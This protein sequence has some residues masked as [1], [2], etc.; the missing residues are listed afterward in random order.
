MDR[1][2]QFPS[3]IDAE[4]AAEYRRRGWWDTET[5]ADHVAPGEHPR[6]RVVKDCAA[7]AVLVLVAGAIAVGL[8]FLAFLI[9]R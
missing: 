5:L 6:V 7:A 3:G 2:T 1:A 9:A 8:A 4:R